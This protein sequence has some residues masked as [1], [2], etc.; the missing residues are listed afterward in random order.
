MPAPDILSAFLSSFGLIALA[1]VGDKSQ[2]VCMALATRYRP[3]PVLL[4]ATVAFLLLN[5]LA[6]MFGAGIAAWL[7]ERASAA[8]V[9]ALFAA[10][11]IHALL[12][13]SER[14]QEGEPTVERSG[15]GV[16]VTTLGLI[17]V[18]E[19]GDKTQL[20]VAG[21]ATSLHAGA[22]WLGA[23]LALVGLSA[24]AVWAGGALLGRLPLH[25]LHRGA[26]GLFLLFAAV[27]AW[28]AIIL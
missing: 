23:S 28:R 17:L 26:G 5:L 20:A 3:W 6:V 7:P 22:I 14:T 15:G 19:F 18:A 8:V 1:E 10:F 4:G 21:L 13:G 11:G 27:A 24:L 12:Q 9:A 25:W 2:L 16:F